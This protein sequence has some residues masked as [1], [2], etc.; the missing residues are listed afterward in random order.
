MPSHLSSVV[1]FSNISRNGSESKATSPGVLQY[2]KREL[3]SMQS[4]FRIREGSNQTSSPFDSHLKNQSTFTIW[5]ELLSALRSNKYQPLNDDQISTLSWNSTS[6]ASWP[7]KLSLNP[8]RLHSSTLN[9]KPLHAFA[10]MLTSVEDIPAVGGWIATF[11]RFHTSG[12]NSLLLV[13]KSLNH[14][15]WQLLE[16][17]FDAVVVVDSLLELWNQTRYAKLVYVHSG[18]IFLR[19]CDSFLEME[20]F[21]AAPDYVLPDTF[22]LQLM[23]IQPDHQTFLEL[24]KERYLSPSSSLSPMGSFLNEF[25]SFWYS[26]S[27]KHRIGTVFNAEGQGLELEWKLFVFYST[28]PFSNPAATVIWRKYV[29]SVYTRVLDLLNEQL[30]L[31]NLKPL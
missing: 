7:P 11:S 16:K 9:P 20:A 21:A 5:L 25:H 29:C 19:N 13:Q 8:K 28:R 4:Q 27:P 23:V 24:S 18:A 22:S 12:Q 1:S 30:D 17:V 2:S 31:C 26:S 14:S 6:D 10:T 3:Q 15:S